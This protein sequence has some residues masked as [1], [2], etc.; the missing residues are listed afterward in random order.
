[1][2][3]NMIVDLE[4]LRRMTQDLF[5]KEETL[6]S[7]STN[8]F[9]AR[10]IASNPFPAWIKDTDSRMIF[11]NKA[12]ED[13]YGISAADYIGKTDAEFWGEEQAAEF[14]K[15]DQTVIKRGE[16]IVVVEPLFNK[17]ANLAQKAYVSKFPIW[18][19]GRIIGIAGELKGYAL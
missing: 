14:I 1:M 18:E 13:V 15:H 8:A 5:I 4:P 10:F 9:L 17:K 6:E 16:G 19:R 7:R 12:Y 2:Q 11:C 3:A